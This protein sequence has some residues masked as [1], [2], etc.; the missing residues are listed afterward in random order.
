MWSI[1]P[2]PEGTPNSGPQWVRTPQQFVEGAVVGT[3]DSVYAGFE[4]ATM[5]S[6]DERASF[7]HEVLQHLGLLEPD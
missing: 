5:T 1:G 2:S 6:A 7:M 4:P 3:D